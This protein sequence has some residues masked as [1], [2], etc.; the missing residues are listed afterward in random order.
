VE[1]RLQLTL[2]DV[3]GGDGFERFIEVEEQKLKR[4]R[5]TTRTRSDIGVPVESSMD[6]VATEKGQKSV[7]TFRRNEAGK[8]ELRLGGSHGKLWGAL[9]DARGVLFN[10]LGDSKFKSIRLMDSIQILPVWVELIPLTEVKV[11]SLPQ[12]LNTGFK[13]TMIVQRYDVIGKAQCEVTL[14]YPDALDGH[15]KALLEQLKV[16]SFLNK[17]RATIAEMKVLDPVLSIPSQT[18]PTQTGPY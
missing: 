7:H 11:E 5:G 1:K 15:V 9:K 16:M 8:P 3:Y 6:E 17:R 4:K 10:A 2:R 13:S 18:T 14:N 12:I